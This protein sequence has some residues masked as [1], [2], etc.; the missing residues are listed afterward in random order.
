MNEIALNELCD[1]LDALSLLIAETYRKVYALEQVAKRVELTREI[2]RQAE[3]RTDAAGRLETLTEH[4]AKL[5][6]A[7]L[8]PEK[9]P[10]TLPEKPD[11]PDL[12]FLKD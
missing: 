11:A 10:P 1:Y 6:L 9:D 7:L 12:S 8:L 4:V 2:H 5:R 3:G